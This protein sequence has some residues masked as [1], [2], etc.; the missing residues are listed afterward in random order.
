MFRVDASVRAG[1]GHVMRCLTLASALRLAGARC[2]FL[3]RELQGHLIDFVIEKGF[4]VHRLAPCTTTGAESA[5]PPHTAWLECTVEEDA[6]QCAPAVRA[7]RPAW[8]VV[9]HYALD[10]RWEALVQPPGTKLLVIDDLADRPHQA[11]LL[12]DQNLGRHPDAYRHRVPASCNLLV[13]PSFALLRPEFAA[14]RPHSLQRRGEEAWRHL[15]VAMGGIDEPN[16]TGSILDTLV[17]CQL[18]ADCR[19]TVVMG[20]AAP[21]LQR[22]RQQA[23]AMPVQT[24]VVVAVDDMAARMAEAD[25]AIGAAGGTAWERCC[26]GLPTLLLALADNQQAGAAALEETGAA[27]SLGRVDSLPSSLPAALEQVKDPA[28]LA[29]M[30]QAARHVTDGQ[31]TAR[32][33]DA[34]VAID[35]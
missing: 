15:L 29:R 1:T 9:D 18:P 30:S 32:V 33:I 5:G 28:R 19:I 17:R 21:A 31:G 25:L 10:A 12:V 3:S 11:D 22:V 23:A 14:L 6:E 4:A 27:L 7:G 20:A 34:M 35:G 16:S 8:L 13:G 2:E 26:L 24:A